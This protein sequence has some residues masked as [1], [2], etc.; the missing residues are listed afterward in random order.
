MYNN[1]S[2]EEDSDSHNYLSEFQQTLNEF[3]AV[4]NEGDLRFKYSLNE[5]AIVELLQDLNDLKMQYLAAKYQGAMDAIQTIQNSYKNTLAKLYV[6]FG[7]TYYPIVQ[8]YADLME[9][10]IPEGD[11]NSTCIALNCLELQDSL[12][13]SCLELE[14]SCVYNITAIEEA[15]E[16]FNNAH[17]EFKESIQQYLTTI[18]EDLNQSLVNYREKEMQVAYQLY[19]FIN[20]Q[21]KSLAGCDSICVDGCTDPT[22]NS[23]HDICPCL[24]TCYC[25]GGVLLLNDGNIDQELIAAYAR[26]NKMALEYVS[27][28]LEN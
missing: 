6:D 15:D 27:Y 19:D 24:E 5:T 26:N 25:E 11:C 17:D 2:W 7:K 18:Q 22:F 20:E 10:L 16:A 21:A 3:L 12:N 8:T 4:D 28:F 14:C 23:L 9:A 13:A 1:S